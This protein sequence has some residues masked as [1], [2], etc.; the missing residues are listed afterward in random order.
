MKIEPSYFIYKG[1]QLLLKKD[2]DYTQE[3]KEIKNL[4]L[5]QAFYSEKM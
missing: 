5:K 1:N 3:E 2:K 4:M